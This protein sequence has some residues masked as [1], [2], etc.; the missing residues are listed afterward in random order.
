[1]FDVLFF[2]CWIVFKVQSFEAESFDVGS[3]STLGRIRGL[4]FRGWVV[5]SCLLKGSV[6]RGSGD[7]STAQHVRRDSCSQ[8]YDGLSKRENKPSQKRQ[9]PE[10]KKM[11]P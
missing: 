7:E 5:Q 6:C 8:I 4:V 3:N 11:H 1:M 2:R 9:C 10:T